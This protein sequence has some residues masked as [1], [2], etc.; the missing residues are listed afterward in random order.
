MPV[1]NDIYRQLEEGGY[2]LLGRKPIEIGSF[3]KLKSRF[4]GYNKTIS[5]IMMNYF[6]LP[7]WPTLILYDPNK[8]IVKKAIVDFSKT[9]SDFFLR[10]DTFENKIDNLNFR[11]CTPEELFSKI[12]KIKQYENRWVIVLAVP[13]IPGQEY[14][15]TANCRT[16]MISG[17]LIQEWTGSGF[18]EYHLGKDKFPHKSAL[19]AVVRLD[20]NGGSKLV[21]K[22]SAKQLARDLDGL[23]LAYGAENLDLKK[24]FIN[25]DS[26]RDL[27]G[28]EPSNGK[29]PTND[30]LEAAFKIW[31][32]HESVSRKVS[33]NEVLAWL[34][35][36]GIKHLSRFGRNSP[37][38]E[39]NQATK[40]TWVL[41]KKL[42]DQVF[43]YY[44]HFEEKCSKSGVDV[45]E[46][47]LT[48]SI[49]KYANKQGIIFWDIFNLLSN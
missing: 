47:I 34:T 33:E 5:T 24:Q 46:K 32:K 1:S 22:V 43:S 49:N 16:G 4:K 39:M 40:K 21:Y 9:S 26:Y 45:R 6:D 35:D 25:I 17:E 7:G 10:S 36:L 27:T 13:G 3:A 44:K 30:E 31:V 28:K 19:H 12:V 41:S 2:L 11:S 15:N 29:E 37:A 20:K 42:I 18:S 48:C 14:M 38:V 23:F 8:P